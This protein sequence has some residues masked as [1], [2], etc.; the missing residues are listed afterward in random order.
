VAFKQSIMDEQHQELAQKL[1]RLPCFEQLT[2]ASIRVLEAGLSQPCFHVQ[3]Q[4][5]TYFAKYLVTSSVEPFAS[6]LAARA[7]IAP[8]LRYVG[9]NW[10]ITEFIVGEGLDISARSV[11][12]QLTTTLALLVRCHSID[13]QADKGADALSVTASDAKSLPLPTL[14]CTSI[15]RQ[16]FQE[17]QLSAAQAPVLKA[18]FTLFQQNLANIADSE[19]NTHQVFCHGDA[20]FSN[21]IFAENNM[22]TPEKSSALLV[23]FECACIAP[24][25]FDL[26]MLMAINGLTVDKAA[27]INT[28]Y[29]QAFIRLNQP[30][31]P[32]EIVDNITDEAQNEVTDT[33]SLVTCYYD[34]SCLINVLWYMSQ[35]QRRKL[36]TYKKM[37]VQQLMLLA[38]R[39]PST[40]MVI[41]EMR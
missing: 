15:I 1:C 29:Q 23:D 19:R 12:E 38:V 36:I 37:A 7:G 5:K 27:M 32:Q 2:L 6:Q 20:N 35:F 24:V 11:D 8:K 10:L 4:G 14:D 34:L 26:A 31:K 25:A 16:L 33:L 18:L 40:N 3:H 9:D 17:T 30:E 28:L 39:Y 13:L 41:N 21:V 22:I